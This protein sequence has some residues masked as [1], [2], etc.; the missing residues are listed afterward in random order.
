MAR[1]ALALLTP[2]SA[3]KLNPAQCSHIETKKH[4]QLS[5]HHLVQPS[6][7]DSALTVRASHLY[8]DP[9]DYNH[10]HYGLKDHNM[11]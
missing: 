1:S 5:L 6:R 10:L 11:L 8:Q 7:S 2:A 9:K 3:L 4:S